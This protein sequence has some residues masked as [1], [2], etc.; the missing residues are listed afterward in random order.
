MGVTE[1]EGKESPESLWKKLML[2]YTKGYIE[3]SQALQPR[4]QQDK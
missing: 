2:K 4:G 1:D 3:N